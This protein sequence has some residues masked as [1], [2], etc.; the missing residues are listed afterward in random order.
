MLQQPRAKS[1]AKLTHVVIVL[2]LAWANVVY[3]MIAYFMTIHPSPDRA[4]LHVP[5]SVQLNSAYLA[6]LVCLFAG[7]GWFQFRT[8]GRAGDSPTSTLM[9]PALFQTESITGMAITE[10]CAIF[11]LLTFFLGAS[12]AT[13]AP[14]AIASMAVDIVFFL[15]RVLKYWSV[16]EKGHGSKDGKTSF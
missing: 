4:Q 13:F 6:A 16:W 1:A 10:A 5:T 11:G 15:P 8:K 14:F 12:L 9:P 2:S 7:P 3:M